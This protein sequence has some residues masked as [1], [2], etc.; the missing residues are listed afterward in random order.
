MC[1][2]HQIIDHQTVVTLD[3]EQTTAI[4]PTVIFGPMEFRQFRLISLGF[5]T[6]PNP[7]KTV[8]LH[9]WKRAGA[10]ETIGTLFWHRDRLSIRPHT[11]AMIATHQ[12]ALFHKTQGHRGTTVWAKVFDTRYGITFTSIHNQIVITDRA[13]QWFIG[14]FRGHSGDVPSVL[15]VHDELLLIL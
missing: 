3:M 6:R 8:L 12:L 15:N 4:S 9:H 5:I 1:Q 11:K 2:I 7:D 14:Y 10:R 13:T